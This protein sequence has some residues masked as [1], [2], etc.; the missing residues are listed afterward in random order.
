[1]DLYKDTLERVSDWLKYAE[2]KNVVLIGV[3]SAGAWATI[4]TLGGIDA[5]LAEAYLYVLLFSLI[6]ASIAGLTSLLPI[7]RYHPIVIGKCPDEPDNL[8]FFGHL[9]HLRPAGLI[10]AFDRASPTTT[11]AKLKHAFAEQIINNAR[12]AM[13]KFRLFKFGI[14]CV[15]CGLL[16]PFIGIPLTVYLTRPGRIDA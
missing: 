11:N 14:S 9:A 2:A 5:P 8:I 3:A 1:M 7:I 13:A 15:L 4:R 16:T 12:I 10:E 6:L